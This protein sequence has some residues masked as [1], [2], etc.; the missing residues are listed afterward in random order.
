MTD[1]VWDA[2]LTVWGALKR[3]LLCP[4]GLHWY[5]PWGMHE[6]PCIA[7]PL[8]NHYVRRCH[9]CNR[10]DST[11]TPKDCGVCPTDP[12]EYGHCPRWLA[13]DPA[14]HPKEL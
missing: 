3:Y 13:N 2:F 7:G 4:L 5:T 6:P 10:R 12:A 1:A 9:R 11:L 14:C 8:V